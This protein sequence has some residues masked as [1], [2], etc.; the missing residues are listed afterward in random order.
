MYILP[1]DNRVRKKKTANESIEHCKRI[2][3]I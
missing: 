2:E 3:M 1:I